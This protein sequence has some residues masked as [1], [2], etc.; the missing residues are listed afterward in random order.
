MSPVGTEAP[1]IC[2]SAVVLVGNI[3]NFTLSSLQSELSFTTTVL[4][5]TA[6]ATIKT[7]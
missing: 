3:S 4:L 2:G 5:L 6:S 1:T 7:F